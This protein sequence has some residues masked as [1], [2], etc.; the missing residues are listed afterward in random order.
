[1]NDRDDENGMSDMDHVLSGLVAAKAENEG[2][3]ESSMEN[4]DMSNPA[5]I[6][7][8]DSVSDAIKDEENGD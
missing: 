6:L 1:M 8:H 3:P 2:V 4:L 7:K 5:E